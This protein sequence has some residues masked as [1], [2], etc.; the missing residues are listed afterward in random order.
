[1]FGTIFSEDPYSSLTDNVDSIRVE[2]YKV[3]NF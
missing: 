2:Q 1:M 3:T